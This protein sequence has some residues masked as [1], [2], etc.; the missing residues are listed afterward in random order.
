MELTDEVTLKSIPIRHDIVMHCE[1]L[2]QQYAESVPNHMT[3]AEFINSA[4]TK[5][6][7]VAIQELKLLE[8]IRADY[9]DLELL[10]RHL[11]KTEGG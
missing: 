6:L 11:Q 2:Y 4:L 5:G 10:N 8:I 3:F 1:S 9:E 7:F